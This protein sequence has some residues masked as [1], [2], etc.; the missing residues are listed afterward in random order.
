MSGDPASV[1]GLVV[2]VVGALVAA[3][4]SWSRDRREQ[5]LGPITQRDAVL[6][7][8]GA[9][10]ER[11]ATRMAASDARMAR[12]DVL[13][14]R[15]D[16]VNFELR[17]EVRAGHVEA[18]ALVVRVEACRA[19][20]AGWVAFGEA[21]VSGWDEVRASES[22]PPLPVVLVVRD[23]PGGPAPGAPG[24]SPDGG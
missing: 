16:G 20:V 22:P 23:G 3:W 19:A 15:L 12:Y 18:D 1:V 11:M 13:V 14:E 10:M 4:V 7:Q 6:A 2:G 21:L 9:A 8:S 24:A 17:G 5:A